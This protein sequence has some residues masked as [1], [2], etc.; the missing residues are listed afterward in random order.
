M[1]VQ[2][3]PGTRLGC[4]SDPWAVKL[5]VRTHTGLSAKRKDSLSEKHPQVLHSSWPSVGV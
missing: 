1:E 4:P 5:P 3:E 2:L